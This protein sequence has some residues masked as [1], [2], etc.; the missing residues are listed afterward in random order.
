MSLV[1]DPR[2]P[3]ID[4]RQAARTNHA[5]MIKRMDVIRKAL[6]S[7][8]CPDT[9]RGSIL[10]TD[11]SITAEMP[12][13]EVTGESRTIWMGRIH[14]HLTATSYGITLVDADMVEENGHRYF[15]AAFALAE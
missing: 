14:A 4:E 15:K 1:D 9:P 13:W 7:F 6:S 2:W 10:Q 3:R 8:E 11:G 12:F 5:R